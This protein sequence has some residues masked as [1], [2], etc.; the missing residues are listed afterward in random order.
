MTKLL[1]LPFLLVGCFAFGQSTDSV[2]KI[3]IAYSISH[4]S[5][6]NPGIYGR[7]ETIELSSISDGNYKITRYI[8]TTASAGDDGK[9][10]HKNTTNLST[11]SFEII[12]KEKIQYWLIQL[13][14]NKNN[15]NSSF[16]TSRLKVPTRKE[17]FQVAKKYD[18]LSE[19]K[20]IDADRADTRKAIG[21]IQNFSKLDSFLIF[22]IP[23]NNFEIIVID[24]SNNLKIQTI[25][26]KDTTEYQ[27]QF[28]YDPLG[29]P[30][31]RYDKRDFR[32]DK[33]ICNLEANTSAQSFLPKQSMISK[34][35]DIGN[36]KELYI[37]WYIEK[38]MFK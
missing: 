21:Q 26:N 36:I 32:T 3:I 22:Q 17:I 23:C 4:N 10:F 18:L 19:L 31:S 13:N 6:G 29:Q 16:I 7:G 11:K 37:K 34:I 12:A 14:T 2:S 35:L 28:I 1:I 20:G 27:C 9:T 15:I 5:W 38:G 24:V 30:I 33:K 25:N 8:K